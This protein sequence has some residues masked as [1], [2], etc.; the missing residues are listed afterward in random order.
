MRRAPMVSFS[1]G[2]GLC[3]LLVTVDPLGLGP[4]YYR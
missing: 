2:F 4:S 3:R 1:F